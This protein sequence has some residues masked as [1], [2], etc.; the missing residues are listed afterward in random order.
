MTLWGKDESM[1]KACDRSSLCCLLH[2]WRM[3][4]GDDPSICISQYLAAMKS[5]VE[6][7]LEP[8]MLLS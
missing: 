4:S 3:L 2:Y 6:Q 8:H 7:N 5:F 1:N